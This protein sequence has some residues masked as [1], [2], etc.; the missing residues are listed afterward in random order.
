MGISENI[1]LYG[2]SFDP[3]HHGH[4]ILARDAVEQLGLS[5]LIFIP[6]AI[7]P[8]KLGR[9]PGASGDARLRMLQAA[10][11][12]EGRFSVEGL[13]LARAGPSYT[14]DTVRALRAQHGRRTRTCI[15]LIGADNVP[16][17]AHLAPHRRIARAGARSSSS[18]AA[19]SGTH[20]RAD[21][22]GRQT[23]FPDAGRAGAGPLLDRNQKPGCQR[24][25]N[26]VS[27]TRRG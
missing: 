9:G 14:I 8:H 4:L 13:E 23:G 16:A 18:T 10:V 6:A 3:V 5:R 27:S 22:P 21:W 1:G 11:A 19:L 17:P 25:E 24:A 12:G 7:S 26:P 15:Y 20:V 2:G